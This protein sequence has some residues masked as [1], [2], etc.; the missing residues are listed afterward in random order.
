MSAQG[1]HWL[2]AQRYIAEG[3]LPAAQAALESTLA[4]DPQDVQA[5]LLLA[6]VF[7]AR[8]R[9]RAACAQLCT[10]ARHPPDDP[11]ALA[12]L[13]YCLDQVGETVAMRDCLS[14]PALAQLDSGPVLARLAHMHQLLG[15]HREALDLMDRARSRGMDTPEFRYYRSLQLQFNGRIAEA[16]RELSNCLAENPTIGRASLALARMR[17][18]TETSNHLDYIAAQLQRVEPGSEDHA[19]FEFARF[20]ELDDLDRRAEAWQALARGN[21]IMY[22]RGDHDIER[23]RRHLA[24]IARVCPV[25]FVSAQAPRAEGPVPIFIVGMPRSGTTLLERI[26]GN[27]PLVASCGELSDFMRQLRWVADSHGNG[28]VDDPLLDRAPDLDYAEV[29]RRYREQTQWRAAGKPF[30]TDKLPANFLM[31]GFIHR[32]LPQAKILHMV[33]DPMDVC[34]SNWKAMFGDAYAYSYDLEALADYY[35]GYRALMAHWHRVMPGAVLDVS[36]AALVRDPETVTARVLAFCGLPPAPG[37]SD[38]ARNRTPVSTLSTAQVREPIHA[39]AMAA[40]QRYADGMQ[41]VRES[42]DD[43]LRG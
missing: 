18:Q 39:R 34:F 12:T 16:E 21:A 37:C 1:R 3:N 29:G 5:R 15:Q 14:N 20:K 42:L 23:E 10:A 19:S 43:L 4:R 2:R 41:P 33:R 6:S 36:Y 38:I 25:S 8:G 31:A 28:W 35:R 13:A 27:H 17:R 7:L 32:A 26:I 9:L 24:T 30:H 40:W 22:A 11:D